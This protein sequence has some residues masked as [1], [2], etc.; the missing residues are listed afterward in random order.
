[1][2]K[3]LK[4]SFFDLIRSRWSLV[5]F[6]FYFITASVL[7]YLSADPSK[8]VVSLMN[9][10][11]ILSPLIGMLFGVINYYNSREFIELLLA[12]PIPRRSI[13]LGMLFGTSLSLTGSLCLGLI[14]PLFIFGTSSNMDF[15]TY[16][17]LLISGVLLTF[18]FTAMAFAIALFNENRLKGFG[19][20]IIFWLFLAFI[21]DGIFLLSLLIF[22]S[23]PLENFAIIMS[24]FNPIDLSRILI[25]LKLDI[26]ALMGYTGAVFNNFFGTYTGMT[27][28]IGALL[29]WC[30][31]P[32]LIILRKGKRKDF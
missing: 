10:L 25:M 3:I 11:L 21:Y 22:E 1:M 13:F 14:M 27:I 2:L 26:S 24:V 20:A 9:I 8:V 6:L 18:I 15:S 7:I 30:I 28:S 12:Q 4:Y 17:I 31:I 5:Y 23:Y 16:A 29:L 32:V 19:I